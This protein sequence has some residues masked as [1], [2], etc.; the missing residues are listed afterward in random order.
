MPYERRCEVRKNLKQWVYREKFFAWN[1][2]GPYPCFFCGRKVTFKK[3]VVHHKSGNHDNNRRNN[4]VAAHHACHMRH[5]GRQRNGV[6]YNYTYKI[7]DE[8][9]AKLSAA[10]VLRESRKRAQ[11]AKAARRK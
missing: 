5:H 9:R 2:P 11:K 7:T 1:G 8:H 3:V 10:A 6:T 4:L